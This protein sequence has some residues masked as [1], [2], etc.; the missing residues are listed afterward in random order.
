MTLASVTRLRLRKLRYLPG[1]AYYAVRSTIQAKRAPG[2]VKVEAK[3]EGGLI[4]WTITLWD[5][6]EAMRSYRNSG[7]HRTVMPKLATWCDEASYV[8]W[9]Q[10]S[11]EPPTLL[12][13]HAR[14]V[15]EGHVSKVRFPLTWTCDAGVFS[16]SRRMNVSDGSLTSGHMSR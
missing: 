3:R 12:Q 8:R 9:T 6:Q 11:A 10:E 15:S 7:P 1:F 14:L 13:A 16:A 2:C 5:S 4:F